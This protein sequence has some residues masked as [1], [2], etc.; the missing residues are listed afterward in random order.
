MR[1]T[2]G[3]IKQIILE[4]VSKSLAGHIG[5]ITRRRLKKIISEEIELAIEGKKASKKKGKPFGKRRR[6]KTESQ[7]QQMAAGIALSAREKYGKK[8]AIERLK[9]AP[10]SMAAMSMKDL[11]K[12]ATIRRGSE[13]P[14]STKKGHERAALPGH[15]SQPKR[16]SEIAIT[17]NS[18][19]KI[20]DK[21]LRKIIRSTLLRESFGALSPPD[22][23]ESG[24]K[25]RSWVNDHYPKWAGE[26]DLSRKGPHDNSYI[27]EAWEKF[28]E[29]YT[30]SLEI[31]EPSADL[32]QGEE[33]KSEDSIRLTGKAIVWNN[34][35]AKPV[36]QQLLIPLIKNSPFDW[37]KK[38]L[39]WFESKIP[40]GHA[41]IIM[42]SS[43]GK[44]RCVDFGAGALW[45]C[46]EK[47]IRSDFGL[48]ALGGTRVKQLRGVAKFSRDGSLSDSEIRSIVSRVPSAMRVNPDE[49]GL[50]ENYNPSAGMAYAMSPRCRPYSIIPGIYGGP[51]V[52]DTANKWE[53][54]NCGSFIYKVAAVGSPDVG[55]VSAAI[56]KILLQAPDQVIPFLKRAG[57]VTKTGK[58]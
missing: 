23:Y 49:W 31:I 8:G 29:E 21:E 42:I 13:V 43:N 35:D 58:V 19:M 46:E 28:G 37:M 1:I 54:D 30:E 25:F 48:F 2:L 50:I 10:K 40:Q 20:T 53:G 18:L 39:K 56:N 4:E 47:N 14:D 36:S 22:S 15:V 44:L 16:I 57:I 45:K 11:R 52:G 24:L 27:L 38:G 34:W 26:N 32:A 55:S 51:I 41:G 33:A 3:Q 17:G 7:A 9:G 5:E 12:L 6:G